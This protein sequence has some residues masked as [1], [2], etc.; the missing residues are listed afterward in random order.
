[1][2]TP[3]GG[4]SPRPPVSRTPIGGGLPRTWPKRKVGTVAEAG[5]GL[6]QDLHQVPPPHHHL[7]LAQLLPSQLQPMLRPPAEPSLLAGKAARGK[8]KGRSGRLCSFRADANRRML[9]LLHRPAKAVPLSTF[10][11]KLRSTSA[12][13]L[14]W[15]TLNR[16]S[17]WMLCPWRLFQSSLEVKASSFTRPRASTLG[18]VVI[19]W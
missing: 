17:L 4:C 5:L 10:S 15:S 3:I 13:K 11:T 18:N 14:T 16:S 19:P 2:R 8:G 1:M 9:G 6:T 12:D 7:P